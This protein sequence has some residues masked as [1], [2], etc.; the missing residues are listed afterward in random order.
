[1]STLMDPMAAVK[2]ETR[3]RLTREERRRETRQR[4]IDAAEAVFAERGFHG[5]S[6]E[7]IAE[8]AGYTRGAFYSNFDDKDEVLLAL[9]DRRIDVE[10]ADV[11]KTVSSATSPTE[12]L[13]ALWGRA[14]SPFDLAWH[15]LSLELALYAMRNPRVR[16]KFAKR[17]RALRR[18]YER[19]IKA[20]FALAGIEPPAPLAHLALILQALDEGIPTQHAIDPTAVGRDSF[21]DAITLLFEA[22]A[23]LS[24]SREGTS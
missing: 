13:A 14:A 1:M 11:S 15:M 20:Q 22:A 17:M 10:I 7:E 24:R 12:L 21:F 19:G 8:R 18:A 2:V 4:L 9:Y 6:V 16:P 5:A 3:K 23:S